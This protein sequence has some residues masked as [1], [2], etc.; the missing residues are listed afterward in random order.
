MKPATGNGEAVPGAV[1]IPR[2]PART[3]DGHRGEC[4]AGSFSLNRGASGRDSFKNQPFEVEKSRRKKSPNIAVRA[5]LQLK[6]RRTI[7]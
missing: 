3:A 5:K 4:G 2:H 7:T 6:F 1:H